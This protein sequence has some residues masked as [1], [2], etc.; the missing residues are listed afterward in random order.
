MTEVFTYVSTTPDSPYKQRTDDKSEGERPP[1][2][3]KIRRSLNRD[4]E[5]SVDF[6]TPRDRLDSV[7]EDDE[8]YEDDLGGEVHEMKSQI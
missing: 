5:L 4:I 2:D 3:G 8:K 6:S 1:A 7:N